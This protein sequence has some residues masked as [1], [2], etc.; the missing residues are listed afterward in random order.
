MAGTV[1]PLQR[2]QPP[3]QAREK[4]ALVTRLDFLRE[5]AVNKVA[6][7]DSAQAVR[8]SVPPS[9]LTPA[10][11]VRH[12]MGIERRWFAI[13]FAASDVP[14][15]WTDD[16]AGGFALEP[17]ETVVGVVRSYLAE[18]ARSNEIIATHDLDDVAQGEGLDFDLRYAVI[19]LIEETARH[20]GHLDLLREAI[21][22]RVGQ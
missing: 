6:E 13:D 22:G 17:G 4:K 19:H 1:V 8:T 3:Q 21:D 10:G 7:L 18:C 20:C 14:A 15:P 5:T 16:G 11:V 2:A 9:T 12:L